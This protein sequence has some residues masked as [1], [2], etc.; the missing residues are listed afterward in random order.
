[1]YQELS[2]EICINKEGRYEASL[3]FKISHPVLPDNFE[4]YKKRFELKFNQLKNDPELLSKYDETFKEQQKL[5]IIEQVET[6]GK[7]W[8]THYLP[9]HGIV[10]EDKDTTKLRI[11]FDA[12]SK[13]CN[14]SLNDCLL[15]GP[16]ITPLIFDIIL[17]FRLFPIAITA[18]IEQAFLQIGIKETDRDYLRFLWV[19]DILK[20]NPKIIRNRFARVV[21]RVT[22][23]P[24]LL[25]AT[26]RK[27]NNQYATADPGFVQK[28]LLSF[29]IDDFTGGDFQLT[30]P[31][32]CIKN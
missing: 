11:V 7:I 18:D 23:S 10:R 26:I 29:F 13:T 24:F 2:D 4:Q 20:E 30:L 9:H 22:S 21:F 6:P 1:M 14:V 16:N 17:R 15:K 31:L 3:P 12:S 25:N 5:G 32:N 8:Q 19:D 27:H 28:T